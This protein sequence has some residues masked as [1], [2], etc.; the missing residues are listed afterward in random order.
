VTIRFKMLMAMLGIACVAIFV[1]GYIS[2]RHASRGLTDAALKQLTGIRRSKAQQIEAQFA[3]Y[4][5]HAATLS[6]DTMLIAAMSEFGGAFRKL[7]GPDVPLDVAA[8]LEKF[9]QADYLGPLSRLMPVRPSIRE[10]MPAGRAPY[11]LQTQYLIRNPYPKDQR[12][13]LEDAKDGSQYSRVHAKYHSALLRIGRNFGYR[14]LFLIDH[15]TGRIVYSIVKKPDF[16]TSLIRG[17]Y[18]NTALARAFESCRKAAGADPVCLTDFEPYEPSLGAPAAFIASPVGDRNGQA[19]VL[20]FE[21]SIDEVDRVISGNKGWEMDG[22]GKSGDTGIVGPDF[23]MRTNSRGYAEDPEKHLAR[24]R[25]RGAPE[26]KIDRIRAYNST[27]LQQEVRLSSVVAALAG[28]EGAGVQ[29]GSAGGRTL[30]SYGPLRIPGLHWTVASRM[31]EAEAL[32]AIAEMRWTLTLWAFAMM[33]VASAMATLATRSIVGP[34]RALA[35]ASKKLGSGD[36]NASVPI[37]SKDELGALSSTFNSMVGAL[38]ES[39]A[40]A[41]RQAQELRTQQES[42]RD[43]EAKFRT[44]YASSSD[45]LMLLDA[46]GFLDCNRA[47]LEMFACPTVE[48]FCKHA[49]ADFSPPNQPGGGDSI[50]LAGEKIEAAV[51]EGSQSFEWTH[52]RANG[53][54]FPAEV[55]LT[56][57]EMGGKPVLQA[58]VRDVTRRKQAEEA[59]RLRARLEAMHSEI[60]AALV[61]S[62]E[63]GRMMQQCADALLRGIEA[64]FARIWMLDPDTDMLVL[65]TS[66][67]MYTHIDGPHSRVRVGERKLGRIAITRKPLETNSLVNEP[68]VNVDW[69]KAHGIV[70]FGGYPLVVQDRLVGVVVVFGKRPFLPEEFSAI[71]QAASRISLG[72]QRRQTERELH[73]A[74][75]RAEEATAAKSMFLAN[76]SHEIR[77]PMNAVIGLTHLALKTELTPKQRDYLT[78]VKAAAGALLGII[79][80]ILDFSK[81]EAGKMEIENSEFR[82]EDVL[83][84]LSTVIGH[85]MHE[86]KLEFLISAKPGIPP[87]LVGDPLR[88]GQI[89]INLVNNAVKFTE[90]GEVAVSIGVE[91]QVPGRVKLRFTV[92]DTGIGMTPEQSSRLFRPFSQADA[93]TTRKFG[94][95]GLGLSI[96]K[97]LVE[98]M[99]GEIWVESQAGMGSTFIFT[100]WFAI[101]S[102]E[103]RHHH[104]NLVEHQAAGMRILLVEDNEM[105]QQIARELLESAGAIV[106]IADHGVIAV[107]ILREGQQPP[108]FDIVLMDVQ[109]PEM[110]GHTATR[111]LR[112]DGRFNDLPIVAMTAHALVEERHRCLEAG[113]NDLVTK[114]IDPD[115]LF[116]ALRRW[117]NPQPQAASRVVSKAAPPQLELPDIEGVNAKEGLSH[118]AGNSRLY[119]NLLGQFCEKQADAGTEIAG[120]VRAGDQ[121]RAQ[122]L[123]HTLKGVAGTLGI[124]AV[125]Q[126]AARLEQAI[127]DGD[128]PV[129]GLLS[130]LDSI[131]G[132]QVLAIRNALGEVQQQVPAP[133]AAHFDADAAA[134]ALVRLKALI[135]SND[136]E[137]AE[138]VDRLATVLGGKADPQRI[139]LLRSTMDDFDFEKASAV[140]NEIASACR[141]ELSETRA[142]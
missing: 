118:L 88:L 22:L 107:R 86:K 38:R 89:L 114:P 26:D 58:T 34:L 2:Y 103:E 46:G 21:L 18:R 36:L 14:D 108:P 63:F 65:C 80:D 7:D 42:L 94:G 48:E 56:R 129:P 141:I 19:G 119:R 87:N 69:I 101:G 78:K 15:D 139:A 97:R 95:T 30:V 66:V 85:K 96:S 25:A 83:E 109:M 76:M 20:A 57:L 4:R 33:A 137:A 112:A 92:Q 77:T 79:N 115:A 5:S 84:N 64:P 134:A 16:G 59:T 45:A 90:R 47:A 61:Q 72:L 123:A 17:P 12:Y 6:A 122:R 71:A 125:Q 31:D 9:Y 10:Y 138:E 74:K 133:P 3:T 131:I 104:Q 8:E 40:L 27:A 60:G 116:A 24:L 1:S 82:F 132:P 32:P 105:N 128:P 68:G 52:R 75:V 29:I 124:T 44:M 54:V 98:M 11:Y 49:L 130:E 121:Q 81:I 127:R 102:I 135:D 51:A 113:M 120:A 91:E 37:T 50:E 110:D 100:A 70:S 117:A 35:A 39:A 41:G 106:T 111:L 43:S 23:L 126:A 140:L 62:Q 99:E 28:K 73:A 67:G 142:L 53:E 136:C 13:Q 93:S 55:L